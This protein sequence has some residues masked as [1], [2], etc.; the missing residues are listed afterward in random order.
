VADLW[1]PYDWRRLRTV[2]RVPS[3]CSSATGTGNRARKGIAALTIGGT[4]RQQIPLR[5]SDGGW[6]SVRGPLGPF[7]RIIATVSEREEPLDHQPLN[8]SGRQITRNMLANYATLFAALV[9]GVPFT[10]IVLQHLGTTTYG[11]WIVLG[12]LTSYL[13]L[14]DV[15]VGTAAV[16]K[17][18]SVI[19]KNQQEN[20]P[21]IVSTLLVFF[22]GTALLALLIVGC[23]LPFVARIFHARTISTLDMQ[24]ALILFGL[25]TSIG[26]IGTI[27]KAILFGSGRGDISALI[28]L[29]GIGVQIVQI[30]AMVLG[31]DLVSL[32]A[33]T[34]CGATVSLGL[35]AFAARRLVS[36]RP[37]RE[38]VRRATLLAF[39]R[40][41]LRNA[42]VS[43]TGVMSYN[44][45]QLIIALILPLRRVTPYDLALS[46]A[47]LTRSIASRGTNQLFPSYAHSFT[48]ADSERQFRLFCQ[49]VAGSLAISAAFLIALI[50]FG[51]Q[52]L[53]LWLVHVPPQTYE[54]MVVLGAVYLLQMPGHQCFVLLTASNRN[55][56][57]IRIGVPAAL[58]NLGL[59][60]GATFWLG[61][62]G[63]AIGSIPQVVGLD[64][65][66]LPLIVCRY[67]GVSPRR[68]LRHA[69]LPVVPAIIVGGTGIVL[70]HGWSWSDQPLGGLVAATIVGFFSLLAFLAS[71]PLIDPKAAT[72]LRHLL[73][74][75]RPF[76]GR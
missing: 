43:L 42:S 5:R 8:T 17:I 22:I 48:V 55:S 39:L 66:V 61:P 23:L 40:T 26:F 16:Q 11:L 13:G 72:Q 50:G 35:T 14:L 65:I 33:I 64:F 67:L 75:H 38:D 20:L 76:S 59:S 4:R 31:G 46:T 1:G 24:L 47:S 19:A 6:R 3:C 7:A 30:L 34:A 60:V 68:Y 2:L 29:T 70:L 74:R 44:L 12:S 32:V 18:A 37:R 41:G 63:P 49:A 51:H 15:G 73:C 62:V 69:I 56:I 52:V 45:D 54:I 71:L 25:S 36:R 28:G 10:R 53:R 21:V 27:P 58:I 57:L 9:V